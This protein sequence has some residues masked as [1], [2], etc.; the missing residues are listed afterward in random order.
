MLGLQIAPRVKRMAV[1]DEISGAPDWVKSF[2]KR[3]EERDE[4]RDEIQRLAQDR[5][6][7]A[8]MDALSGLSESVG[9]VGGD[10]GQLNLKVEK[11]REEL[12]DTR[13]D[14]TG[15][16]RRLDSMERELKELRTQVSGLNDQIE[17]LD[18]KVKTLR[19][20]DEVDTIPP[21]SPVTE[22]E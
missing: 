14:V 11:I 3:I 21:P 9:L 4:V 18:T 5:V 20:Q 13:R 16:G 7:K 2:L 12:L 22:T 10:V 17:T 6:H 1:S 8:T 15:H 19:K